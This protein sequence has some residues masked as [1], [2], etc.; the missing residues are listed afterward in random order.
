[1]LNTNRFRIF[2]F[3]LMASTIAGLCV[4]SCS[5]EKS[6]SLTTG[7]YDNSHYGQNQPGIEIEIS[8][9]TIASY[10]F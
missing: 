7:R 9:D 3:L 10:R 6:V 5:L 8:R 1:M 2:M 4:T